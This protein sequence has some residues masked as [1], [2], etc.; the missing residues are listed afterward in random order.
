[1]CIRQAWDWLENARNENGNENATAVAFMTSLNY[2]P[3]NQVGP[4]VCT[5]LKPHGATLSQSTRDRLRVHSMQT[6]LRGRPQSSAADAKTCRP[7]HEKARLQSIGHCWS[8][9]ALASWML[10]FD[11]GHLRLELYMRSLLNSELVQ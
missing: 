2:A 11:M 1:M 5:V 6:D 7:H 3:L 10:D 8:R 9:S 4:T